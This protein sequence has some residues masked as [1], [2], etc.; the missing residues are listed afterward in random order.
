MIASAKPTWA[1][2]GGGDE[3]A[4]CVDPVLRGAQVLVD[5]DEASLVHFDGGV[6][7]PEGLR[8]GPAADRHDDHVGRHLLAFAEEHGGALSPGVWPLTVTPVRTSIPRRL[9][10]AGDDVDDVGVAARQHLGQGLEDGHLGAEVGDHRGELAADGAAADHDRR[11][12]QV[13]RARTSSEV[14]TILP[15][16]SKPG[17]VRSTD[18]LGEDRRGRRDRSVRA[19]SPRSPDR[20]VG[21]RVPVPS[22]MVTLRHLSSAGGPW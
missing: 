4:D 16:T 13:V 10:R 9:E 6:L 15:S 1:S 19:R 12:G 8:Q 14:I 11:P 20:A 2:G 5:D 17:M 18:P 21:P 7:E 22:K 3:V